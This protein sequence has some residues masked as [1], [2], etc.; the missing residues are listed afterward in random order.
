MGKL[1]CVVA[2]ELLWGQKE[3]MRKEEKKKW[4]LSHVG[5]IFHS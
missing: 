2:N 1:T 5:E 4:T 3:G